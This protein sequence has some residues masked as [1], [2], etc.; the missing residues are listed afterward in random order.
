ML[1][2]A[3]A[4]F[5]SADVTVTRRAG[6]LT[7]EQVI[8]VTRQA[9]GHDSLILHTLVSHDLRN[10]LLAESRRRSVDAMD[11]MGPMLD[12]LAA[13]LHR[14]P[15][16]EPGL[17]D[18]LIRARS[19]EIEAVEFAFRHDDGLNVQDLRRAE[20]VL[21][22]ASRTMKTPTSLFLAYQG[23]FVGNVPLVPAIP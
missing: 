12:R 6:I 20:I 22:G 18:Q 14:T 10:L 15:T 2:A 1:L 19:R 7:P 21:V 23:W 8:E 5:D 4:Q 3:L 13:H 17:L 9:A 11:L 16:E